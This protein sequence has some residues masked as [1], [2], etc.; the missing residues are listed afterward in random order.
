MQGHEVDHLLAAAF[1]TVHDQADMFQKFAQAFEFL[2][3][4]CQFLQIFHT[5]WGLWRF[6]LLPHLAIARFI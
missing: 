5:P 2:E 4:A 6:I 3:R 1:F